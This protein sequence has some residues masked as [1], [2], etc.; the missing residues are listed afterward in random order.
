MK[1]HFRDVCAI[2]VAGTQ[3]ATHHALHNLEHARNGT[4][5]TKAVMHNARQAL[6]EGFDSIGYKALCDV[7]RRNCARRAIG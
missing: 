4:A 2:L 7:N 3:A 1:W 6:D 5:R